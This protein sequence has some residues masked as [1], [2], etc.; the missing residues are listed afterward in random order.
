[1]HT[2]CMY[3]LHPGIECIYGQTYIH[4]L[5]HTYTHTRHHIH[6]LMYVHI[7]V[8]AH[9]QHRYRPNTDYDNT[10]DFTDVHTDLQ[11]LLLQGQHHAGLL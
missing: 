2:A 7:Y 11:P 6:T 9:K 8:H 1:M 4:M 3:T 10:H 5:V